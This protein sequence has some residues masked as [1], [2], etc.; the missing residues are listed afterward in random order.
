MDSIELDF[1][2]L[3]IKDKVSDIESINKR[4][5]NEICFETIKSLSDENLLEEYKSCK[6]TINEIEKLKKG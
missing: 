3:S 2:K 5:Q 1:E 6:S 4:I